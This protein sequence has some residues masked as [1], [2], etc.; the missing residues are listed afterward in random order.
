[1]RVLS[2]GTL[3][4]TRNVADFF[5]HCT[6]TVAYRQ[7]SSTVILSTHL[8]LQHVEHDAE[9]CIRARV[10]KTGDGVETFNETDIC[11][12][13]DVKTRDERIGYGFD[14]YETETLWKCLRP[15]HCQGTI[16]KTHSHETATTTRTTV[17]Q[18]RAFPKKKSVPPPQKIFSILHLNAAI[19]QHSEPDFYYSATPFI[20]KKQC[21]DPL[22]VRIF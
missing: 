17:L 4:K 8:C 20:R 15:R 10:H 21:F 3:S 14:W 19:L 9:C 11:H 5:R 2:S 1:M 16:I 22:G 6:L 18:C 13:T 12:V 7:L